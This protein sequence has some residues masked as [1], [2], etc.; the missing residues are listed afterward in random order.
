MG[1]CNIQNSEYRKD[2]EILSC[3]TVCAL[4]HRGP[5]MEAGRAGRNKED[6]PDCWE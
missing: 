2:A 3:H 5:A 6:V 4:D 1:L